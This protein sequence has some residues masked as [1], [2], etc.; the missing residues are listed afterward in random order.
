M[1]KIEEKVEKRIF[2]A[3]LVSELSHLFCCILPTIISAMSLL[4][5]LGL[6]TTMPGILIT[7]HEALH[8]WE[9]H[10]ITFSALIVVFG[11]GLVLYNKK[12][13]SCYE[14]GCS[15]GPCEPRKNTAR[16]ILIAASALFIIN[17]AVY[18]FIHKERAVFS[19]NKNDVSHSDHDMH[20]DYKKDQSPSSHHEGDKQKNEHKHRH[21]NK[22]EHEHNH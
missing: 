9:L 19:V 7:V 5:G 8:D 13:G 20:H 21:K 1:K 11:W 16:N 18:L 6:I 4:S 3:I 22:H 15:H 10:L 2:T 17:L 12:I 14:T